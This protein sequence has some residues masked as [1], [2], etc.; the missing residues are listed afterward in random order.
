LADGHAAS[1]GWQQ[2]KAKKG[3]GKIKE[4]ARGILIEVRKR[5]K[6]ER[7]YE[8]RRERRAS[9][10]VDSA[11]TSTVIRAEDME[12]V[13]ILPT[14]STKVF[15]NANGTVSKAGQKAKLHYNL[16]EKAR[17]ADT[18]PSLALNSLLSTSKL[19]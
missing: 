16:R 19:R 13:K 10:V 17:D 2:R 6:Q 4:R 3:H 8:A 12:H 9:I 11:A 14:R 7:K 18:V 15:Y 1:G 5:R